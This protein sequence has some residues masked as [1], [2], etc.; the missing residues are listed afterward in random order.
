MDDIRAHSIKK[1]DIRKISH[2]FNEVVG[3]LKHSAGDQEQRNSE[4]QLYN[5]RNSYFGYRLWII[6]IQAGIRFVIIRVWLTV[7]TVV[8]RKSRLQWYGPK[9]SR[10]YTIIGEMSS[11]SDRQPICGISSYN[12]RYL[13]IGCMERLKFT[14]LRVLQFSDS[15]SYLHVKIVH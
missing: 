14:L 1:E 4:Y 9:N 10:I 3:S 2:T 13:V 5:K 6:F 12:M 11:L 8:I 15:H 7:N